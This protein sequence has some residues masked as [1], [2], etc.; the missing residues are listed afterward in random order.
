MPSIKSSVTLP[1]KWQFTALG[2]GWSLETEH[3]LAMDVRS[4]IRQRIDTYEATYSR[5]RPDSLVAQLAQK[6]GTVEFP[7]DVVPLMELYECLYKS[8]GGRMT[9]L[10]GRTLEAAGY[11]A[12]YSFQSRQQ[13]PVPDWQ[14]VL[15]RERTHLTATI[16][17][18]LDVGAAG[19]G[20]L[21]DIVA[22]ILHAAKIH[23][24]VIDASGDV[25]HEGRSENRIGLE[26]PHD[27]SMVIG[28][29]DVRNRSLCAS[30]TNRRAW[31]NGMHHIFDPHTQAPVRG[32][33]ATWVIAKTALVADGLA[34]ALFF[35]ES[36][37]LSH[38]YDFEYVR[39]FE[40][41]SLDYSANFSGELFT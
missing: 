8:T 36:E 32:V 20:Y 12:G 24:Y 13:Q 14:A 10:I 40:D 34:T 29:V 39:M 4:E 26:H 27:P 6:A 1:H 38:V 25:L 17:L 11:D 2:T 30:A 15:R 5:F 33:V 28:V 9:P 3:S 31:G 35:A 21:V 22:G 16:P 19:K 18:T 41:G 37:A 23:D 7:E